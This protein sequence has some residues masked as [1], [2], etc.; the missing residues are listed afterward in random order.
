[1]LKDIG[2]SKRINTN[3]H[4]FKI[5]DSAVPAAIASDVPNDENAPTNAT[6]NEANKELS[7]QPFP[8]NAIVLSAQFWDGLIR[9]IN[10]I[11]GKAFKKNNLTNLY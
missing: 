10:Y 2:D 9:Q 1:M 8:V 5:E 4:S 7:E 3:L 6:A 11:I